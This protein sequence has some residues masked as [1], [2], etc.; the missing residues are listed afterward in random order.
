MF[1]TINYNLIFSIIVVIT[2]IYIYNIQFAKIE[3]P[4]LFLTDAM[5][6]VKTGDLILFKGANNF[7]AVLTFNYFTHIGI[8][9]VRDDGIP[10]LFEANGNN[11][12]IYIDIH[13]PKGISFSKLEERIK[14]YKGK[15]FLK[16]LNKP[17]TIMQKL[18]FEEWMKFAM[19]NMYYNYDVLSHG[20]KKGLGMEKCSFGT[21][22]GD[23]VFLS[24]IKMNLLPIE[25][26]DK[27]IGHHL[28][29]VCGLDELNKGYH[30]RDLIEIVDS[31]YKNDE[32]NGIIDLGDEGKDECD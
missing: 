7:N 18:N 16:A 15:C 22:C 2:I 27:S 8:V 17:I 4:T 23:M 26:Y 21:N 25:L 1:Y 12:A 5:K 13:N 14:K 20:I 29:Y 24:L 6:Q 30:F 28:K 10:Y 32:P 3:C 11:W 31:Q 9:Y 19:S